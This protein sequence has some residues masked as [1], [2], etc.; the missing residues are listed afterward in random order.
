MFEA[1]VISRADF[2]IIIKIKNEDKVV[3][4]RERFYVE[5]LSD[6]PASLPSQ[7]KVQKL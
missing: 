7:I 6:L 4:P 1:V 2:P 3:S 5:K